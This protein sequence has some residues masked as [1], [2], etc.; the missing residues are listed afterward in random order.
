MSHFQIF[1]SRVQVLDL[2]IGKGKTDVRSNPGRFLGYSNESKG[3]RVW[4]PEQKKVVIARDVKFIGDQTIQPKPNEKVDD[5]FEDIDMELTNNFGKQDETKVDPTIDASEESDDE[6]FHGFNKEEQRVAPRQS[7]PGEAPN[8]Y[9]VRSRSKQIS[10]T[11]GAASVEEVN[12]EEGIFA[13]TAEVPVH[14]AIYSPECE[15]WMD[16][17]SREVISV[18]SVNLMTVSGQRIGV[19][20]RGC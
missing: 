3:Y 16:A 17:M 1:G 4:M 10:F 18:C 11:C 20:Q 6:D 5:P 15:E 13:F 12:S 7:S 8:R 9:N 14:Q 19:Q 2:T